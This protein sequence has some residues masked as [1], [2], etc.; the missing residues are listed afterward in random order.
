MQRHET[1]NGLRLQHK[2][3]SYDEKTTLTN[4]FLVTKFS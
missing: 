2:P 1:A 3:H 4:L